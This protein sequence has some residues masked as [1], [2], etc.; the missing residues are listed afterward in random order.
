MIK[1]MCF[2]SKIFKS[3]CLEESSVLIFVLDMV[4][5]A[6]R[7]VWVRL[8]HC[9]GSPDR[10]HSKVKKSGNVKETSD[11][12]PRF[13]PKIAHEKGNIAHWSYCKTSADILSLAWQASHGLPDDAFRIVPMPPP[14]SGIS[15]RIWKFEGIR[16]FPWSWGVLAISPN[17]VTYLKDFD[18]SNSWAFQV[19]FIGTSTGAW[20]INQPSFEPGWCRS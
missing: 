16:E 12:Q 11:R 19:C 9:I 6:V 18:S 7:L 2:S 13:S 5:K 15:V 20:C 10:S 1:C 4:Q 8:A 17:T 14:T 3:M